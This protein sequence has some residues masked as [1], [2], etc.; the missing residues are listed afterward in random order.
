LGYA[1]DKTEL[2]KQRKMRLLT[3]G[4][5]AHDIFLRLGLGKFGENPTLCRNCERGR[6]ELA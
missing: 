5:Q 1:G 4:N 3:T 2:R 6:V